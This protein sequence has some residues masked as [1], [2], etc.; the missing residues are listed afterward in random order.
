MGND[1]RRLLYHVGMRICLNAAL[2]AGSQNDYRAAGISQYQSQSLSALA[3]IFPSNWQ[4]E[5]W[6]SA[7]ILPEA[8]PGISLRH[9]PWSLRRPASRIL[10]EQ[11]I[12]PAALRHADLFHGMAFVSP[13]F[14]RCP[15]V[16][17]LYD[18]SFYREPEHLPAAR[19]HYLSCATRWSARRARRILTISA[20]VAADIVDH[21]AIPRERIDIAPPGVDRSR[22]YPRPAEEV[23]AFRRQKS[24]PERYWLCVSTLEPRK[25]LVTLLAAY[26]QLKPDH[27]VPLF[28]AGGAGWG[29]AEIHSCIERW[30]LRDSV[31]LPGFLPAEELPLWYNGA[32][33][34][35]FPS[36]HEGFG[37]PVLEAMACGVPTLTSDASA[38]RELAGD[39]EHC[40]PA[41]DADAWREALQRVA[42]GEMARQSIREHSLLRAAQYTWENTA[43]Q[44]LATYRAALA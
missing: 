1:F 11:S 4:L 8:Y 40:I 16:V 3:T 32:D 27:R 19:R 21:L 2:L 35:L 25:N 20:A 6:V 26:A 14:L 18:L 15:Q 7:E 34:F 31:F 5:A 12:L 17:T 36:V 33:W 43:K 42:L 22:F 44:I 10:W 37:M 38:L 29:T 23:A 9:A 39:S 13:A 28:L 24:L 30:Q 41:R